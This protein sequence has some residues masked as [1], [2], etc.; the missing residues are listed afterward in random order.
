MDDLEGLPLLF[1]VRSLCVGLYL[2]Q[3]GGAAPAVA[4]RTIRL[5][6]K[7]TANSS[8]K[9]ARRIECER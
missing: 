1:N 6:R 9:C 3:S 2:T 7:S 8:A 4:P 5:R